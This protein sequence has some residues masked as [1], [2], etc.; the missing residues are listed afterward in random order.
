M[1]YMCL[2]LREEH[3]LSQRL[4]D[5]ACPES[6][7]LDT[8]VCEMHLAAVHRLRARG[9]RRAFGQAC[10]G[11]L[12]LSVVLG[13]ATAAFVDWDRRDRDTCYLDPAD[14]ECVYQPTNIYFEFSPSRT[15]EA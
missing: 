3:E 13:L 5:L 1:C 15:S 8:H 12:A 10:S 2:S 4:R 9:L 14:I 6:D 11:V 7:R